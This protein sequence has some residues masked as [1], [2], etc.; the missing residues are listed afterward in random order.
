VTL[1]TLILLR[2]FTFSL[3]DREYASCVRRTFYGAHIDR[4]ERVQK[5][6]VRYALHHLGWM[7][8]YD[9]P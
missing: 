8:M 7:D 9:L 1:G 5:R 3:C 6:F 4:I 2:P